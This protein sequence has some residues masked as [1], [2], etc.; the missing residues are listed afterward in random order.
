M[1]YEKL[2][3]QVLKKDGI[4][5]IRKYDAHMLMRVDLKS[6]KGFSTLF[7]YISG[8]NS[9]RQ[10]IQMTVPVITDVVAQDY[11]AFTMPKAIRENY[12]SPNDPNINIVEI[13]EKTYLSMSYKGGQRRAVKAL[14]ALRS[15]AS[16]NQID[17]L[18]AP[19]LLR[20]QPPFLPFFLKKNDLMIEI[21]PFILKI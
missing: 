12:P 14:E 19:V 1:A 3:F 11:I 5:E 10:K 20:Y 21:T 6:N 7:N 9:K 13:P 18:G 15:Y 2:I 8:D 17:L 4:F 16:D